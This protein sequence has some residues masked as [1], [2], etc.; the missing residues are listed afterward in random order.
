MPFQASVPAIYPPRTRLYITEA[1]RVVVRW[2]GIS[3]ICFHKS[4]RNGFSESKFCFNL[5]QANSAKILEICLQA[6]HHLMCPCQHASLC[7]QCVRLWGWNKGLRRLMSEEVSLKSDQLPTSMTQKAWLWCNRASVAQR[8]TRSVSDTICTSFSFI[9]FIQREQCCM[10][11]HD[12]F[13]SSKFAEISKM[14]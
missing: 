6:L 10:L 9:I 1:K 8:S 11:R 3:H 4:T 7:S 14:A 5:K 2:N 13:F 12:R